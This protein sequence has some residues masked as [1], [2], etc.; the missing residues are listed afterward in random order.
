MANQ[1][2]I[3]IQANADGFAFDETAYEVFDHGDTG[4]YPPN[5]LYLYRIPDNWYITPCNIL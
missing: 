1:G 2:I 4:T 5:Y 3:P